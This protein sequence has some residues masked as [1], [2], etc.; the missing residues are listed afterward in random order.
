MFGVDELFSKRNQRDALGHF[1]SK[2]DGQGPDGM[3][4]SELEN[5]WRLNGE[6]IIQEVR[7]GSYEPGVIEC[8]EVLGASGKKRAVSNLNVIDRFIT[9]LLSQKLK[10]YIEPQFQRN[11]FAYQEGK[12]VVEAVMLAR[13]YMEENTVLVEVDLHNYFDTVSLERMMSMLRQ[14]MSDNAVLSLIEKYLYCKLEQENRI[15]R[16]TVGLVQGMATSPILS[17]WYLHSLDVYMEEQE[18]NWLRFA[19]NIYVFVSNTARAEEVF[20]EL[21]RKIV[22]EYGLQINSKKSGVYKAVERRIL[23]YEFYQSKGRIE[24][25][26]HNYKRSES[27]GKWHRGVIQKVNS[28]YHLLQDGVL[29]KKDYS[30]LFENQDEKHHIPVE[31]V[32]QLN[33]YSEVT[34]GTA[35]LKTLAEKKIRCAIFDKYGTLEGYFIPACY[36]KGAKALLHQCTLYNDTERRLKVAKHMERAGIH[37]MRSNLRYYK[38]KKESLLL[39]ETIRELSTCMDEI[40]NGMDVNALLLI[41]ARARQKYYT[42]FN[43]ILKND[44]FAFLKRTRQPPED[45]INAL[46]SFGNTLLYNQFLHYIWRSQLNPQIGVV[47]ATNQRSHSLNLDF[48]D[49]FKPIIVDRVIFSVVNLQQIKEDDFERNDCGGIYLNKRGKKIFLQ[50]FEEKLGDCVTV[51]GKKVSYRQ[52]MEREVQQFQKFVLDGAKY[53]PYKYY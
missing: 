7:N 3:S 4:V 48:A 50:V 22:T 17:N 25:R 8:F 31:V 42:C 15:E 30:L 29:N 23:G 33:L 18:L 5:Y 16:K 26:K 35:V 45:E 44:E 12:G 38:K 14:S 41:E 6:Q 21:C 40:T 39:K 53:K 9:R 36:E 11:S 2:K 1:L 47:H 19:D 37:N 43:S 52:L 49:I 32:E 13:Q 46:I 10:R 28:E 51:E 24:V 27:H 20:N 34:L